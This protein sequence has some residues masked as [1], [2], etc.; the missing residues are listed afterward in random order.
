MHDGMRILWDIPI[1]MDDGNVLRADVFLP[2]DEGQ[3]PVLMAM[4]PYGKWMHF[5]DLFKDQW[6]PLHTEHPEVLADSTNRYQVYEQL[7]PERFVPDGYAVM[8]ID[9]RGAGRS[10]GFLNVW[11]AREAQDYYNCIEWAAQ[12]PWSN[13][14][15]GLSGISYLA[16]NQWQVAALQPPHL[17]AMF[18]FEGASDYYRDMVYHGGIFCTFGRALYGPAIVSIQNGRGIR[19]YRSRITGDWVSG[20]DTL[21]EE[22]L[23]SNRRD[24]YADCLHHRFATDEFWISRLPDFTKIRTP[25][26]S[27][28][29]IGGQGLHLRGNVEG[30]LQSSSEQKW[31]ELHGLE[32]W[33]EYYTDYGVDLQKRFFGYFL[34]GDDNGWDQ[35]P[36][37]QIQVRHPGER[38]VQRHEH[39]WPLARTKWTKLYL[40]PADLSMRDTPRKVEARISYRGMSDGLVF[41]TTPLE[42]ETE[43]TG[44]IAVRLYVSS[45]T[46]DADLFIVLRV[47]YPDLKELVFS[48]QTDP[49][50]PIAQGW[51]RA[52]RRKL[53]PVRSVPYRPYHTHDE[54]QKLVPGEI[55]EL[56]IEV[57]PTCVV[58][59]NGY[60]IGLAIRGRDYV[61]GG[62]PGRSIGFQGAFTG[63][64]GFRHD[65]ARDRPASVFNGDVTLHGGPDRPAYI[66]LPI[67]PLR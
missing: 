15:V 19:G 26:L 49:H 9:S 33:T 6:N 54:D 36:R 65:E 2:T 37:V 45:S 35:Q 53:D 66:M 1:P 16:M 4:G 61:Y 18:V 25:L 51:L 12:Q 60:R 31:L 29:N 44:P 17:Y 59:P 34:K 23:G 14:K 50:T 57:S 58:V 38:F 28:A 63:V 11:S 46:T 43:I 7:N 8:R 48:G 32:H 47:F 62:G 3:F 27:A 5:S 56:D 39:E 22:E 10:P 20:P 67:I 41:L 64:G 30:F 42:Q 52:S 13:G 55:Y 40:D 24:W 21:T